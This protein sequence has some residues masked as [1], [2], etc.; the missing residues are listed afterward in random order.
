LA[1]PTL[2]N[3]DV[4]DA[5][6]QADVTVPGNAPA[7]AVAVIQQSLAQMTG[8]ALLNAAASQQAMAAINQAATASAIAL[9]S[10]R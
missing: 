10:R 6:T 2:V 3:D 7:V 9:F 5:V 8:L 1:Y 4:T